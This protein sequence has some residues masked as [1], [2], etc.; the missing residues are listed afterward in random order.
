MIVPKMS[1][2]SAPKLTPD[3]R[4][5]I[6]RRA[7]AGE[8]SGLIA[9]EFGVTKQCVSLLKNKALHPERFLKKAEAKMT[10]K[11]TRA[12]HA[13]FIKIL[14]TSTPEKQK[15]IPAREKWTLDHGRQLVKRLFNKNASK[16]LLMD[17]MEPYMPKR[18]EFKFGKPQPPKKHHIN[19]LDPELAKDKDYVK[20]YLSPICEQIAWREY[21][22]ALAD[23]NERFAHEEEAENSAPTEKPAPVPTKQPPAAEAPIE[24]VPRLRVG[25][26]AK[27]KGSPFTPAK[28]KKK[29]R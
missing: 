8:K 17:C 23:W 24:L 5:E 25:K 6:T 16:R 14:S 3:Q 13:K 21:E 26:H 15:L 10:R 29:R 28:R 2:P 4:Q 7:L 27:S 12:E 9:S 19:Q 18:S 1:Y 20:Y 22:L 11:L